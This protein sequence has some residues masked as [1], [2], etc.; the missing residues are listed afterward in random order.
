MISRQII[1]LLVA[2]CA[3]PPAVASEC[4]WAPADAAPGVPAPAVDLES[5]GEQPVRVRS[6]GGEVTR[7]GDAKLTGGVTIVQGEREVTADSASYDASE[8]RFEVEGDVEYRAPDLR[9]KGGA[10]SWNALGTGEFTGAEFELPQRPARGS[11]ES[12]EMREQGKLE[13]S[14]VRFTTCPAGEADW[15]LRASSIEIDQ[16]TQQGKGRNVRVD[17]KGVPILYTPVI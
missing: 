1:A 14:G 16:R 8:R 3:L 9:L 12:L 6:G 4:I 7:E 13:L 5:P 10:G 2:A 17:L 11:A 15:E